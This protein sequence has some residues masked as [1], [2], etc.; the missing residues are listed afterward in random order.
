MSEVRASDVKII[1]PT[2]EQLSTF[3]V[4]SW[5]LWECGV[6]TFDWEYTSEEAFYV[7]EGSVKVIVAGEEISF[8]KGDFVIFPAGCKCIWNISKAVKKRYTFDII[9]F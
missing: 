4:D 6:K 7:I 5:P 3:N 9:E 8:S 1:R 2:K